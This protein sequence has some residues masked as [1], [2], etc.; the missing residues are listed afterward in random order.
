MEKGRWVKR[1]KEKEKILRRNRELEKE[2][3]AKTGKEK[4]NEK[5]GEIKRERLAKRRK[6]KEEK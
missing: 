2:R 5:N 4:E 1:R 6:K 3:L